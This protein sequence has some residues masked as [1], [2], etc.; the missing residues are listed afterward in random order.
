LARGFSGQMGLVPANGRFVR[1]ILLPA[2]KV[3]TVI[4][5]AK[6][7]QVPSIAGLRECWRQGRLAADY[8]RM[9]LPSCFR[10]RY[11]MFLFLPGYYGYTVGFG[12]YRGYG[13]MYVK[14]TIPHK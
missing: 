6:G 13:L 2:V 3:K 9:K 11:G 5:D 10:V 7:E 14:K 12:N 1:F 4:V 8:V